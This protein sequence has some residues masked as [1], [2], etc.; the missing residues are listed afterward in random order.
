MISLID[1]EKTFKEKSWWAILFNL[2]P[3][4][5]ITYFLVNKTEITP[6]QVTTISFLLA[7]FSG[8]AFN[9][10]Y[11]ITGAILY[12]LSY[13]LDIVDGSIARSKNLS[14]KIGAFYDVFTDWLKAPIL[15][16]ILFLV[17]DNYY[18]LV[19]LYFLL[20]LGCL[21]NKYNDMLFFQGAKSIT[22]ISSSNNETTNLSSILGYMQKMKNRNIQPFPSSVEVEGLLLFFY[23]ITELSIFIYISF[24][25]LAF[26]ISIKLY[27]I[28]EKLK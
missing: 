14:S 21:V 13:I 1:I 3:A 27:S 25:I 28:V 6:N 18:L 22:A 12:Q 17:T 8:I 23:P 26:N 9:F 7:I 16:I 15:F 19:V 2:Y 10:Q 5:Y 4:K 11:F 20:F 24:S